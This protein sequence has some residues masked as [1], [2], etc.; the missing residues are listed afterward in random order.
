MDIHHFRIVGILVHY[1]NLMTLI[2]PLLLVLM[3]IF[4]HKSKEYK[5]YKLYDSYF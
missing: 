3:Y 4:V 2:S 1:E 5:G